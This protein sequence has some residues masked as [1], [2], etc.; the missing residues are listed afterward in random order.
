MTTNQ[1]PLE[2]DSKENNSESV[3]ID[4]RVGSRIRLR[5]RLLGY[6]QEKLALALG[7]SFQ[8]VQ[9]YEKG[10]NRVG[11]SRLFD[12]AEI[13]Q[14]PINFFFDE[15]LNPFYIEENVSLANSKTT[16]AV[17]AQDVH[18]ALNEDNIA[19]ASLATVSDD[20]FDL[21]TSKET[22]NLLKAYYA[23]LDPEVRQKLLHLICAMSESSK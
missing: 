12:I 22:M 2:I 5:R 19:Q 3:G 16:S 21:M 18:A 23:I 6:S 4:Q 11:A 15:H 9:K 7:L 14:V 10:S 13:L 17:Q 20:I 1:K 8:Q